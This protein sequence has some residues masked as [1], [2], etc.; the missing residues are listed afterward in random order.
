MDIVYSLGISSLWD[1]VCHMPVGGVWWLNVDRHADAVSLLNHTLAAQDKQSQVAAIVM[2]ENPNKIIAPGKDRG[3]EKIALF[4][5]PNRFEGLAEMHRDLVC[6]LE[7]GNY[8]FILLCAENAWQNIK[9]ED[10]CNWV[11][12]S[13]RWTN[14]HR[15]SL[16][17]LNSGHDIDKQLSPLL[18]EYRSLSG[19]I[20]TCSISPGGG[21]KKASAPG[22]SSLFSRMRTAGGWRRMKKRWCS[23]AAMRK[24]FSA[25]CAYWRGRPRFL[26]TG[27]CSIPTTP[28]ST[29]GGWRRRQR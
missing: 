11:E 26:N 20:T 24:S 22:S 12:K 15:C 23:R 13:Y 21:V 4:S 3:P 1:E 5:M 27:R 10:L 8:L 6:S 28:F 25:I 2:G 16:L 18:R 17:V 29:P 7:P 9:S 14:Y 19:G